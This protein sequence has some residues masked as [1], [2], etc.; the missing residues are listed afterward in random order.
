MQKR[1]N[2]KLPMPL[3]LHMPGR[4]IQLGVLMRQ[5]QGLGQILLQ[6]YQV[7]FPSFQHGD[8]LGAATLRLVVHA[9]VVQLVPADKVRYLG[10][11]GGCVF[12]CR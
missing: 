2:L 4:S 10:T 3:H 12:R 8:L 6:H 11:G 9:E 5:L 7:P 1:E